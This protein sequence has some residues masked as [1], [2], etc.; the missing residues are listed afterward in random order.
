[1]KK[2]KLTI[3]PALIQ[4]YA[5]FL[6]EQE[7]SSATI[8]KYVHDLTVFPPFWLDELWPRGCLLPTS[9]SPVSSLPS[10]YIDFVRNV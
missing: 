10:C 8:Q 3:T 5:A 4:K 1:M 2:Q 6:H 9:S 7:R